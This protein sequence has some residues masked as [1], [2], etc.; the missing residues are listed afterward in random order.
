MV[1]VGSETKLKTDEDRKEFKDDWSN[2][3]KQPFGYSQDMRDSIEFAK[4]FVN[5]HPNDNI[6][7]VG[8]SKGG[9]EA[10]ANAVA[11]NRRA[12][13]FNPAEANLNAY[14]LDGDEYDGEITSYVVDGEALEY[15]L[16]FIPF[17]TP[18]ER[19]AIGQNSNAPDLS[20]KERLSRHG[21]DKIIEILKKE[22]T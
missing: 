9:A 22:I 12:I 14:L 15:Y 21:I 17:E 19:I 13:L 20:F 3:I 5:E 7:F 4:K 18:A 8:H 1:N 2:N 16:G 11:T 10:A 6:I